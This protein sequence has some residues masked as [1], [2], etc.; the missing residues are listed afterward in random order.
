MKHCE[1]ILIGSPG[2][3]FS[4]LMTQLKHKEKNLSLIRTNF[5]ENSYKK[6]KFLFSVLNSFE[7]SSKVCGQ[8]YRVEISFLYKTLL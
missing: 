4:T 6:L 1:K 7:N 3:I 2:K 5:A 8:K